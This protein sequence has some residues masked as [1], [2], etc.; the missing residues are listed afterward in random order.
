MTDVDTLQYQMKRYDQLLKQSLDE[1]RHLTQLTKGSRVQTST[2]TPTKVIFK[3]SLLD[4]N[5]KLEW[6]LRE[7]RGGSLISFGDLSQVSDLTLLDQA[8]LKKFMHQVG[9]PF[10]SDLDIEKL[11]RDYAAFL[12]SLASG[13]LETLEHF[14]TW[15]WLLDPKSLDDERQAPLAFVEAWAKIK[16]LPRIDQS[17]LDVKQWIEARYGLNTKAGAQQWIASFDAAFVR[18]TESARRT[19]AVIKDLNASDASGQFTEQRVALLEKLASHFASKQNFTMAS[20]ARAVIVELRTVAQGPVEPRLVLSLANDYLRSRQALPAL[21]LL[22][23]SAAAMNDWDNAEKA[24]AANIKARACIELA[25]KTKAPSQKKYYLEWALEHQRRALELGL[26]T[27]QRDEWLRVYG[28]Q[29]VSLNQWGPALE[30]YEALFRGGIDRDKR[31]E[32]L[33]KL[34]QLSALYL[35]RVQNLIEREQVFRRMTT[36]LSF[37]ARAEPRSPRLGSMIKVTEQWANKLGLASDPVVSATLVE[38]K[39]IFKR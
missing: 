27:P 29:L 39:R 3:E 13:V 31:L 18:R 25:Q 28:E 9:D 11:R 30:T 38:A 15:A 35:S 24:M 22:D 16:A 17:A 32:A 7:P 19:L 34:H 1:D 33:Q 6:L 8:L 26:N 10:R 12:K 37:F 20:K 14:G 5:L 4:S 2:P 36:S 21:E 23:S